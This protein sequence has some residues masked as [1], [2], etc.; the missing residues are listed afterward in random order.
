MAT[1][2][3]GLGAR[4]RDLAGVPGLEPRLA[5]PES[6]GLPIT[7]YPKE[8]PLPAVANHCTGQGWCPFP[9]FPLPLPPPFA[10]LF[11]LPA[12]FALPFP[13]PLPCELAL[14]DGEAEGDGE[15]AEPD[16]DVVAGCWAGLPG[17][18]ATE[19]PEVTDPVVVPPR[20][21]T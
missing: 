16:P 2:R 6:A 7:P 20:F 11:P 10:L 18:G 1:R 15:G 5:E 12:P 17:A 19:P 8:P 4:Y 13:F 14:G 9:P 21:V 3:W